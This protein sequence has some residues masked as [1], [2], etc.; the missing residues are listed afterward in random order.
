MFVLLFFVF[1]LGVRS[2]EFGIGSSELGGFARIRTNSG[3]VSILEAP[4]ANR[5]RPLTPSRVDHMREAS[6]AKRAKRG[7]QAIS[8]FWPSNREPRESEKQ[9]TA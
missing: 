7:H 5:G 2:W 3:I 1:E 6:P 9:F 8:F 4:G